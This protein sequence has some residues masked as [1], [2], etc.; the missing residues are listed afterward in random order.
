MKTIFRKGNKKKWVTLDKAFLESEKLSWKAKGLL[1]YLLSLPD[2]WD[3]H[4]TEIEQ[5]AT[6]GI[7][8][9]RATFRE[10]IKAGYIKYTSERNDKKQIVR[11]IY[12]IYETLIKET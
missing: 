12:L 9:T 10:L 2:D 3:T 8:S 4:P 11:G 1:A 7:T 6:D 5:H